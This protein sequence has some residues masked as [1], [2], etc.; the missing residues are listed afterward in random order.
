MPRF[1]FECAIPED[2]QNLLEILEESE[3]QGKISLLYTRRPDAYT[4]FKQEG[5][6]VDI[7]VCRD[8]QQQGKI[9]GFGACAL[10]KLF[11][12]GQPET[13]GY[14]FGLRIRQSYRKKFPVL[15]RGYDY[16]HTLHQERPPALYLTAILE[17]NRYA[18]R[19]LE[20]PRP[21]MPA[22]IPYG[23]Y[24]VYA[25]N[26]QR[27]SRKSRR[28]RRAQ[29]ADIP[30]LIQ[31]FEQHG[32]TSQF[33]PALQEEDVTTG[34]LSGLTIENFYLLGDD[35]E[36]I[37]AAGAI[38][39]QR[40][41]KQYVM[42]N[43]AGILKCLYP[44]SRFF[45]L[46]GFPKLPKPGSVLKFFTLSFWAVKENDPLI[47]RE[48]LDTITATESYPFFLIGVHESHPLRHVVQKR[49]H[50]NYTSRLYAVVWDERR[51]NLD[52]LDT[53]YY[54]YLECGML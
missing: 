42:Q 32:K 28:L 24:H 20:K 33:F 6:P 26:M 54:P 34:Y 36:T 37:L 5:E 27:K 13:V 23:S 22:Y 49:P 53:T 30:A 2:G 14:L 10:R 16:L 11:V 12:N 41:Y 18:Q 48:F 46:F 1:V 4:S 45:P 47:F 50:I 9:V 25:L 35:R 39:D 31:F 15:F 21:H 43:Y 7:V 3:F 44:V 52:N 8:T 38:W 40:S 19:L 29:Q 51:Q 17:E